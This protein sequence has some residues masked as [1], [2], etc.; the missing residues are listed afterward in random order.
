MVTDDTVIVVRNEKA[1]YGQVR[2]VA[3]IGGDQVKHRLHH[4]P[5]GYSYGY[6]GSGPADLA[7]SILDAALPDEEAT[8][9]I[10][11]RKKVKAT[12]WILHQQFRWEFVAS[13]PRDGAQITVGEVRRWAAEKLVEL[14]LVENLPADAA[15]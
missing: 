7:L 3:T 9:T 6:G 2:C 1:R 14:G 15:G 11:N 12:A 4:S 10:W 5:T 13:W 8:A